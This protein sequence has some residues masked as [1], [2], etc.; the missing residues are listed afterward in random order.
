[1]SKAVAKSTGAQKVEYRNMDQRSHVLHRPDMYIGSIR[2]R[3][4]EVNLASKIEIDN[5]STYQIRPVEIKNN[6]GLVRIFVEV[7]SNAIDNVW[8]SNEFGT[9][10]K[11]IKVEL[12]AETGETSIWNDGLT[13]HIEKNEQ[14]GVYNPDMIFGRLLTSSNYN[15]KEDRKTS[16]RNGLGVKLTNIFS[17]SFEVKTF[18]PASGYLYH[19]KWSENMGTRNEPKLTRPKLKNGYT[20]V[21]WTPD[22]T[23]FGIE[24]YTPEIIG[25]IQKHVLDCAMI[26][27]VTVSFNGEKVGVKNIK[28]YAALWEELPEKQLMFVSTEDSAVV[29]IPTK[30]SGVVSFVNG[31]ETT[32]GGAHVDA[33]SEAIFRPILEKLNTKKNSSSINIR[34][35]RN[36]FRLFVVCTLTNPEFG[37][38]EKTKL[39][40]PSPKPEIESKHISAIMKWD[41]MEE[42]RDLLRSK[43]L[44][45][46]KKVEKKRGFKKIDGLDPANNAGGK[47]SEHCSLILCEGL[48]AKTYAVMGIE[49]GAY[50]RKGRDWFGIYP[51]RG[52][53]LNVRN[54][55]PVTISKNREITD[56]IQ[57]LNL[58]H[59]V[60]YTD[61]KNFK[62]LNYGRLMILTDADTDG[63]HI[64]GLVINFFHALFPTLFKRED[65][66]VVSMRTPIVRIYGRTNLS[67]YTLEEFQSYQKKNSKMSGKVKY[68]K[69]LGTS[70]DKEIRESFGQKVIEYVED[71]SSDENMNKVFHSKHADDR[72]EWLTAYDEEACILYDEREK[73]SQVTITQFIDGEMIKFSIDDCKRSIPNVLDGLK[74]SH[75]KIL[76]AALLKGLKHTGQTMKVAQLAGFVAEKT[77][78]HH[79][80]QCLFDTI[81]KMAHEF[82][83]SN[84][85]PLFFR[86][87]QFGT[88]LEGGKD[89]ANAR[90]IFTKLEKL[91]R[92]IFREED[93]PLLDRVIDD[94]E[95]VEPRFYVPIIPT[96]LVNGCIAGIGT[97][98]STSV[99]AYNPMDIVTA[100]KSW[101][102]N[103]GS[104]R[105]DDNNLVYPELKPWY[106]SFTGVVE[107]GAEGRWNTFG[108]VTQEKSDYV[109]SELPIGMWTN[110][111]KENVEDLV[112]A[113]KLKGYKNYSTPNTVKFVLEPGSEEM[114]FTLESLK[115]KTTL[116]N[117]NMVF[118][119]DNDHLQKFETVD[120]ILHYFCGVR[121][122]YYVHRKD[123]ILKQLR[124]QLLYLE[125]R[126][127]FLSEVMEEKLVIKEKD[128]DELNTELEE[129]GYAQK[130]T[131]DDNGYKYLLNQPIRSFS[132][133]KLG[134]LEK[135]ISALKE[136]IAEL[137]ETEPKDMWVSELE[138]FTTE[139]T[140]WCRE[141]KDL[142]VEEVVAIEPKTRV[143][144]S[145]VEPK[146]KGGGEPKTARKNASKN[147]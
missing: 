62:S 122:S 121:L 29:L 27:G 75:R 35:L 87:G 72:K 129:S 141:M 98:W 3:Q 51:L 90:Y 79:G 92:Y 71:K 49:V 100:I 105:D 10:V 54:A 139:Y 134:L 9:P 17:S 34:E 89:A 78:Y 22:F 59:G 106:R 82:A 55:S 2:S 114:E 138:E 67:F 131:G 23:R 99:P 112:E 140:K 45:V 42:V 97:G 30:K 96:I 116:S 109:V 38:Q 58:R 11:A 85:I 130:K 81:T 60:D 145:K 36:Y 68:F 8:R 73:V 52:K 136:R 94:G 53:L 132:K 13:I 41:I 4:E 76:Y 123:F 28:E 91:T 70:N 66:F 21:T 142:E 19:Q 26:T 135:D 108:T 24:G 83:G 102:E 61:E 46:L 86:D 74:E 125:N 126:L 12:N 69:G 37:S 14:T 137:E 127:R 16:G 143:K 115:L 101:I 93:D 25:L 65:P 6:P 119:D 120:E 50:G 57:A 146:A 63:I 5:K 128:E 104:S 124:E 77:N 144:G 118:F 40:A 107:G 80:E 33:W 88:R 39:V 113:K 84:N 1:M 133:Q 48:S 15:D 18:D 111:F 103:D 7:L 110:K 20:E 56:I 43:D 47:N 64:A 147:K 31:V 117:T 32:E 95:E 44:G